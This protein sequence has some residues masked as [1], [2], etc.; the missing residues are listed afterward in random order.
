[1]GAFRAARTLH[2]TLL[3]SVMRMPMSIFDTTPIGRILQRFTKE[4]HSVDE[5]LQQSLGQYRTSLSPSGLI[6]PQVCS[7]TP[8]VWMFVSQ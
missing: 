6:A 3:R 8:N 4:M 5:T 1:L 7:D 2:E